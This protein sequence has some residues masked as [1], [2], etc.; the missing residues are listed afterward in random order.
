V[1]SHADVVVDATG[2]AW[3]FY[4]TQQ[5]G[6]NASAGTKG[7]GRRSVLQVTELHEK[8]GILIVDRNAPAT[9]DM[10]PPPKNKKSDVASPW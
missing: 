1:G 8:N 6:E 2:R 9:I 3:L 7:A 10:L 5:G 4:F